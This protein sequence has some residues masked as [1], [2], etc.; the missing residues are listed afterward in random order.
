MLKRISFFCFLLQGLWA[1]EYEDYF[2]KHQLD[3]Y[4][5]RV[6]YLSNFVEAPAM[7]GAWDII[8]GISEYA[9]DDDVVQAT[10]DL[11]QIQKFPSGHYAGL[12]I[13]RLKKLQIDLI[14]T[15]PADLKSIEFA[16]KFGINFLAQKTQSVQDVLRDLRVQAEVLNRLDGFER[17]IAKMQEILELI[18]QRVPKHHQKNVVEFFYKINHISGEK[19]LDTDILLHGGVQNI[20]SAYL[21]Q[22]RGE[23][24]LEKIIAKDPD[25]I[26]IWWLSPLEVA[27]ILENPQLKTLRAIKNKEVYKLPPMDIAG[28]RTPLISL[29]VAMKAYPDAFRDLHWEEILKDYYQVV[30]GIKEK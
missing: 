21:K 29:F 15:Y 13:E 16:K 19:S 6:L 23:I 22:G 18:K 30:L 11:N 27:D 10:A 8:K 5:K 4:P 9:F 26:F 3:T 14:V 12:D 24:D 25:V 20:G 1:L 17:K 2:G 28:P 7:L